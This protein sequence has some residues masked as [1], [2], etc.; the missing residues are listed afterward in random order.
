[1]IR[2]TLALL[3]ATVTL[4]SA[5]MSAD[6]KQLSVYAPVAT[7]TLLVLDRSG[8]E[9]VGLLELLDPLGRVSSQTSGSHWAIRFNAIDGEFVAGKRRCKIHGRDFD[10][11]AP[12]LIENAR[13]LVPLASLAALLPRFLGSAVNFRE[14]ARRLFIGEVGIQP[15]F[16]LESGPPSR[17]VLNFNAPVNPTIATEPGRLRM[18]FKRD[19]I[20]S[21]GSQSISF[22]SKVFTQAT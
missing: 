3:L 10:L 6:E 22:D 20:L 7:Y 21:P 4:L 19:P 13:G 8:H 18:I 2:K 9:Y 15:S 12:F 1:M 14:S 11:T 5:A 17:L 16:Q